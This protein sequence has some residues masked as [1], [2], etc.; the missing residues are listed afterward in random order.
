MYR[1]MSA[2]DLAEWE[3]LY[4][5]DPWGEQRADLRSAQVAVA[6]LAPH[7]GRGQSPRLIN[8]MPY[9]KDTGPVQQRHEDMKATV[10]R[11]KSRNRKQKGR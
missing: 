5:V 10:G 2:P 3:A 8:F 6:A 1:Q 4:V 9:T 7:C 11:I